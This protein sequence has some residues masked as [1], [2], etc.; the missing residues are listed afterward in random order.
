MIFQRI[1]RFIPLLLQNAKNNSMSYNHSAVLFNKK[2]VYLGINNNRSYIQRKHI[3]PS[4]HAE[5]D[6]FKH[7]NKKMKLQRSFR[8]YS[9]L[10]IRINN[11]GQICY[12]KPCANC[13]RELREHQ[14]KYIY[15]SDHQGNIIKEKTNV[16]HNDHVSKVY[17]KCKINNV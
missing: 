9:I 4:T 16:I 10:V 8:K 14:I 13:I 1:F 17:L 2:E 3:N 5:L 12:S 6:T 11:S 7:L 15:Y